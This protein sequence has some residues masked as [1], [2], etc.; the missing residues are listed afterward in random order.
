V[1]IATVGFPILNDQLYQRKF[2]FYPGDSEC[3]LPIDRIALHAQSISFTHPVT[4][5][6]VS[7]AAPVPLDFQQTIIKIAG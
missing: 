1:H 5:Q 4:Q 2:G 7:F 3:D 6:P